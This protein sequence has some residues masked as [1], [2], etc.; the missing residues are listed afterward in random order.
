MSDDSSQQPDEKKIHVDEDW[1]SQVQ[2]EKEA[3]PEAGPEP[4]EA[5]QDGEPLPLPTL[6]DMIIMFS[7]QAYVALGL[8][9][10]PATGQ[11][12]CRLPESKYFIDLLALLQEKTEGNRDEEE[13]KVLED[14]LH[15]LRM[16]FLAVSKQAEA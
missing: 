11:S 9:P 10:H 8:M 16:T 1:K 2:S 6:N 3:I 15:E 7:T 13:S 12:N 5:S 4:E 14:L